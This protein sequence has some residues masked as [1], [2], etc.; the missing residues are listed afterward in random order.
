M[1][2]PTPDINAESQTMQKRTAAL[3]LK[4]QLTMTKTAV[5]WA[6]AGGLVCQLMLIANNT[7]GMIAFVIWIAPLLYYLTVIQKKLKYY[8]IKYGV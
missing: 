3:L 7:V 1:E 4:E 2:I 6:V 8:F 5:I